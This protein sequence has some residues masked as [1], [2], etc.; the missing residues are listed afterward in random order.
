MRLHADDARLEA[1]LPDRWAAAHPEAVLTHRLDE[2][3]AKSAHKR[4]RR[5][6]RRAFENR[7]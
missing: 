1:M 4:D 3:R 2:S 6:R 5:Q 7:R